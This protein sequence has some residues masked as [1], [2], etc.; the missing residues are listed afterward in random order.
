MT[1]SKKQLPGLIMLL[2]MLWCI[3]LTITVWVY[4]VTQGS[5]PAPSPGGTL[6]RGG[7]AASQVALVWDSNSM[8]KLIEG[9]QWWGIGLAVVLAIALGVAAAVQEKMRSSNE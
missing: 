3:L 2:S 8:S 9:V 6:E 1:N 7:E 4:M 5:V